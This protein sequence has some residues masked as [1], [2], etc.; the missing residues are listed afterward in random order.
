VEY[1]TLLEIEHGDTENI[2]QAV[3]KF[4]LQHNFDFSKLICVSTDGAAV[5]RGA[6]NGVVQ[7][8]RSDT[9]VLFSTHCINHILALVIC[10]AFEKDALL[11]YYDDL[12]TKIDGIFNHSSVSASELRKNQ[13]KNNEPCV[14]LK[15]SIDVRWLSRFQAVESVF[16]SYISICDTIEEKL[17][18]KKVNDKL[19]KVIR[20]EMMDFKF[21]ALQFV[22]LRVLER[23]NKTQVYFQKEELLLFGVYSEIS[24]LKK[25]FQSIEEDLVRI[26][27]S[28]DYKKL[29]TYGSYKITLAKVLFHERLS[30]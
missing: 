24:R 15:K 17:S 3:K 28:D 19:L 5:F 6:H 14:K 12:F 13:L 27:A 2:Y 18:N 11:E 4:L 29:A 23:I 25:E 22:L 10:K 20:E 30:K 9:K 21:C 16:C 1:L 8:F 7:K 26:L